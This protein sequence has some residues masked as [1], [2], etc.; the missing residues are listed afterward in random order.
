MEFDVSR[1]IAWT[2]SGELPKKS[3]FEVLVEQ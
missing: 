3:D 2:Y 1:T